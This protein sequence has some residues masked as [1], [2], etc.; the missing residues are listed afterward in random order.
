MDRGKGWYSKTRLAFLEPVNICVEKLFG[1]KQAIWW[2]AYAAWSRLFF[3]GINPLNPYQDWRFT[4]VLAR[5]TIQNQP[6]ESYDISRP[7]L[8]SQNYGE[9]FSSQIIWFVDDTN[10]SLGN[11][12]NPG[13]P[14]GL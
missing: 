4:Q 13:G 12:Q 10:V 5:L 2:M 8:N 1:S 7:Y 6:T 3:H 11:V 14:G 9:L